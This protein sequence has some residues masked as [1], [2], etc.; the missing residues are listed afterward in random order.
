MSDGG[1]VGKTGALVFYRGILKDPLIDEGKK[2]WEMTGK[3]AADKRQLLEAYCSL[4]AS[5]LERLEA[6]R[7]RWT[8]DGWQ[9]VVLELI[10]SDENLF[11]IKAEGLRGGG[12][13]RD[14][15]SLAG[16]DL[17]LL[18]PLARLGCSRLKEAVAIRTGLPEDCLPD[19]NL[20]SIR[21][22]K[23]EPRGLR[24]QVYSAFL[25]KTPWRE[26]LGL[27]ARFYGKVGAG[28]LSG[29]YAFRWRRPE[30]ENSG[31]LVPVK[32]RD[33]ITFDQLHGY[34]REQEM[35]IENTRQ[36]LADLPANNV[37]LYGSR[38]TGKSSTVKAL[39]NQFG[40]EGLRLVEI[41]KLDLDSL[42]QLLEKL[43]S[44]GLRFIIFIDDLS[45]GEQD[46]QYAALKAVLEGGVGAAPS[47]VLIYATSN[48]RHFL[49]E[50]FS[51]RPGL[52]N[53]EVR[54]GDTLQE[55]LSLADRFG[56]TVTFL[57]P[58]QKGYLA[59]V[60]KL[61]EQRG[62]AM[63]REELRR[64]ALDWELHQNVRSPRTAR[65]FV[66]QLQGKLG[67]EQLD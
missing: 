1:V 58:D 36:F 8:G 48:R 41:T 6:L 22:E 67:L 35:V 17:E 64:R 44:R 16:R 26:N 3:A 52:E 25:G 51:D 15:V 38:G 31:L 10:L 39:L 19:W 53:E 43:Q 57:S 66:D 33:L 28:Q 11:S 4:T 24:A 27:L 7:W 20:T 59:I 37:L 5:V 2:V 40:P 65:Q 42:P 29:Y 61:T 21:E 12:P 32:N 54:T 60:E 45:F 46:V 49:P 9:A 55:K 14:L 13:A 30:G 34:D 62:I 18:E 23:A 63:D 56:M 50:R 47:N